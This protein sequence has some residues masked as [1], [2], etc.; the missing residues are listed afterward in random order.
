MNQYVFGLFNKVYGI[1]ENEKYCYV[2]KQ[3]SQPQYTYSIH[4]IELIFGEIKKDPDNIVDKLKKRIQK[5]NPRGKG[6]LGLNL[7]PFGNPA[8][9]LLELVHYYAITR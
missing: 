3:F 2:H 7:L 6:I 9:I 4:A 1:K 5:T 8:C